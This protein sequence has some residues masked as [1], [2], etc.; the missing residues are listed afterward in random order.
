MEIDKGRCVG[1]G[2]CHLICTMGA[3]YLDNDGRSVV[4]QDQCVECGT[5]LRVLRKEMYPVWFVRGVRRLLS[6]FKLGYLAEVDICPG[7]AI[8]EPVLAWPRSLRAQFSNPTVVH[9]GTGVPGRGTD[10]IKSNDVTGRLKMGEAGLVVE[11][12][13]PGLGATFRD[14]QTIAMALAPLGPV[15]EPENPVTLLMEDKKT[16]RLRDDV[17]NEKVLSAI[18]EIK[19]PLEMIPAFLHTLE[20]AQENVDTVFSVGV[21]SRCLADGTI[22]HERLVRQAGYRLS[23][24]GKTNL[25][26]GRPLFREEAA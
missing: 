2:N 8:K 11:V 12:G 14:V 21:A 13:R 5:C 26:L 15:F 3:I 7:G 17:L 24:N 22:P 4:N 10:E 18:I 20:E 9:P 6:L 25:G 23:A 19:I 16:G 1:C